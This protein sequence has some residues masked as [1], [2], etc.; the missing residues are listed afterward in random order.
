MDNYIE[1]MQTRENQCVAYMRKAEE[2]REMKGAP[3]KEECVCL[4][5]AASLRSEMAQMSMGEESYYQQRRLKELNAR[6]LEI[7]KEIDPEQYKLVLQR[8]NA[9]K[10]KKTSTDSSSSG[11]SSKPSSGASSGAS[12]SSSNQGVADETVSSWF[13]ELPDTGFDKVAGMQDIKDKLME[14][15]NNSHMA[16][17]K[18]YLGMKN[19]HSYFFVGPP[20]C[21][22]TFIIKAFAKELAKNDYKYISLEGSD[23]LSRYVGDAEKIVTRLFEEAE[24]AAPCIIFID[25]VDGVCKNRSKSNLP[26]YAAS[27]TTAFLTGYNRI[28]DSDKEIVF[29]GATNFP[30]QVDNAMLDRVELISIPLPDKD[31]REAKFKRDLG[32]IIQLSDI[33]YS[34]MAEATEQYNYRDM[35]RLTT[36]IK[37][38]VLKAIIAEYGDQ[39]KAMEALQAG[40]FTL[41]KTLFECAKEDVLPTPK[42]DVLEAIAAWEEKFKSGLQD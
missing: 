35:E 34:D 30:D 9:P 27:L 24:K 40:T 25:E 37:N 33:T 31:A 15:I 42:D 11:S 16:E 4:Q 18:K 38:K 21:G 29:I 5:R 17:L 28:V 12:D 1:K 20:G 7:L 39:H 32:D 41:N 14:C 8:A 22:K 36:C 2:I 13:K 19:L 3:S 10:N 26:E 23:I 6:I